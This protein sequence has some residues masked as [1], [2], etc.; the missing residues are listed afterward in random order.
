MAVPPS[1]PRAFGTSFWSIQKWNKMFSQLLSMFPRV[2][3]EKDKGCH[4][5]VKTWT[6]NLK[7]EKEEKKSLKKCFLDRTLHKLTLDQISV[8]LYI[9]KALY[10]FSRKFSYRYLKGGWRN[11]SNYI[12]DILHGGAKIW[13]LF[14]SGKT[15]RAQRVSKILFLPWEN[16]IHIFKPLCNVL[17]II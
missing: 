3:W 12:E 1:L 11:I 10:L 15:I 9:S 6:I 4:Y 5:V 16:K 7:M 13:I 14:S 2:Y 8:S 17:F